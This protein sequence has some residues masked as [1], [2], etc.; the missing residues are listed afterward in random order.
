MGTWSKIILSGSTDGEGIPVTGLTPSQGTVIHTAVT[1]VTD[2]V[3]EI[4]LY[5]Y[6]SATVT[7]ELGIAIG[8]TTA[9]GSRYTHTLPAGELI[10]LQPVMPGLVLR[11]AKV[12]KA[13][14]TVAD[15]VNL[16]GWVNR[17]VT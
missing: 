6:S 4:L 10:G 12:I 17:Y 7:R 9:T 13:F 5:A 14:V 3:Y 11:N 15:A 8:P 1:G 16:F 2:S